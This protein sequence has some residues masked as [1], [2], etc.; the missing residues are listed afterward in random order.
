[1]SPIDFPVTVATQNVVTLCDVC[2]ESAYRLNVAI[3]LLNHHECSDALS[4]ADDE[5]G[6]DV[7]IIRDTLEGVRDAL[8]EASKATGGAR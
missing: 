4:N 8:R 6:Y 2:E 3:R 5:G 7:A 1:M